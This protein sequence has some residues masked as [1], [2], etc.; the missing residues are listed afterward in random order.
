[1]LLAVAAHLNWDP[2]YEAA[3][4]LFEPTSPPG[5]SGATGASEPAARPAPTPP[6]PNPPQPL[7]RLRSMICHSA[8]PLSNIQSHTLCL[9]RH[10][11][12]AP[13][14]WVVG[15]VNRPELAQTE[16]DLS[17]SGYLVYANGVRAFL[18]SH[19]GRAGLG[20]HLEFMGER[21]WFTSLNAHATHEVWALLPGQSEPAKLQFPNPR[22]PRSSMLAA[23]D[24]L[25]AQ[26]DAATGEDACAC[27]GD[28]GREA[29]E[30]AIALRESHRRGTI[31]VHLPLEDRSLALGRA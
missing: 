24:A 3:R 16:A 17:G 5:P 15:E 7:G 20:W 30:V 11:A 2:W 13:V 27:P 19:T 23:V 28:Y 4:V 12:G 9:F 25:A 18:N 14:R 22:R 8:H 10:F 6:F 1:V 31:P 21:G 26:L 29:L